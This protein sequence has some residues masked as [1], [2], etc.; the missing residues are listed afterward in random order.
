MQK[1]CRVRS[2]KIYQIAIRY[3]AQP[4]KVE[5]CVQA[6]Q[7]IKCPCHFGNPLRQGK[8]PLGQFKPVSQIEISIS[9][10]DGKHVR[11]MS[12]SP[13]FMTGES[14]YKTDKFLAVECTLQ[15]AA[16]RLCRRKLCER[17]DIEIRQAPHFLL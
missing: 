7:W 15:N 12:R 10:F 9:R 4:L 14:V 3:H 11:V 17:N 1:T 13:A 8:F 6:L 5:I 16:R 2:V